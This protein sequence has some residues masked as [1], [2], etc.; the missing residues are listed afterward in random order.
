VFFNPL[1]TNLQTLFGRL[2]FIIKKV[3]QSQI[4]AQQG[5]KKRTGL[6]VN[7]FG[8]VSFNL[9]QIIITKKT[10]VKIN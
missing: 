5:K 8:K 2:G 3:G 4:K 6:K 7:M 9:H 10:I 1:E